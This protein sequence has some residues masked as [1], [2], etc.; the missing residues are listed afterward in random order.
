MIP[1]FLSVHKHSELK[2]PTGI[3]FA[4]KMNCG[5]SSD[6]MLLRLTQIITA[7]TLDI[8]HKSVTQIAG[9]SFSKGLPPKMLTEP[10]MTASSKEIVDCSRKTATNA[11][12]FQEI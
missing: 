10:Q 4:I 12:C 6:V 7:Q 8:Y 2:F 3:T 1:K 11:G 9:D 5:S